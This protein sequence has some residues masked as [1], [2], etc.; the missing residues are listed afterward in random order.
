MKRIFGELAKE[1][2]IIRI[3]QNL[4]KFVD[5]RNSETVSPVNVL[6]C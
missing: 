6:G 2:G 5:Y 4:N 1:H 3:K